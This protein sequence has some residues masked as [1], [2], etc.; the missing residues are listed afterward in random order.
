MMCLSK[1]LNLFKELNVIEIAASVKSGYLI[2]FK[3]YFK[4]IHNFVEEA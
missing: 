3:K 1:E 2:G 4:S